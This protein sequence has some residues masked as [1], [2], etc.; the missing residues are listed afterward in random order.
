MS[1]E[2][3]TARVPRPT[4]NIEV[5][6]VGDEVLLY[7]PRR[8]T[9][10]Y[11]NPTAAIVFGLCDG[12]RTVADII[13]AIEDGYPESRSSIAAD[14]KAALDGLIKDEMIAYR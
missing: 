11:L 2:T 1:T 13:A 6:L 4:D 9:A 3:T 8:T 14:V 12:E 7:H 10:V 5:E